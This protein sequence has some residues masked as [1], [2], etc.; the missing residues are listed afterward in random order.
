MKILADNLT[1]HEGISHGFFGA[2]GGVSKGIYQTLNCGQGSKD[3]PD[4]VASNRQIVASDLGVNAD[5]L[6][7]PYQVHSGEAM[8]VNHPWPLDVERPRLDALVTKT[9]GLAI[10][11]MTAD[12]APVLFCDPVAQI[13]GAAHAGWRGAFGGV[14][15][16]TIEKMCSL[17]ASRQN[18]AATVGPAISL[19]IYEVGDEFR[20]NILQEDQSNAR[21]FAKP[22]GARKVHFDLQAYAC[23][24]LVAAGLEQAGIIAHCTFQRKE[25]YFSYRRSQACGQVDYGRQISAIVIG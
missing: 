2:R 24:R 21:F 16:D 22:A 12:C 14:L 7:S 17:G 23:H 9:K 5:H 19:E 4:L 8:I 1:G 20:D 3:D 15:D 13:V 6:V 18:I 25:Q 10:G 11:I